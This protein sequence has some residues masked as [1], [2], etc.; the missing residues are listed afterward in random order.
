MQRNDLFKARRREKRNMTAGPL[1]K[2]EARRFAA[3]IAKLAELLAAK[4]AT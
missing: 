4:R 1:T 3:N 2:D